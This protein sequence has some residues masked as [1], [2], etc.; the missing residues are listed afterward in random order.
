VYHVKPNSGMP[1][2]KHGAESTWR[3][4]M[5]STLY[6]TG[7]TGSTGVTNLVAFAPNFFHLENPP[8]YG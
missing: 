1:D 3:N 2:A 4:T 8:S 7:S 5:T 6:S